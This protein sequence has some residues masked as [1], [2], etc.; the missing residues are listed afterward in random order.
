MKNL[1]FLINTLVVTT[2]FL[3]CSNKKN[4]MKSENQSV[5]EKPLIDN[6]ESNI[7]TTKNKQN[8]K[9][10]NETEN[11]QDTLNKST[12]YL[13]KENKVIKEAPKHNSPDQSEIDSIKK[14]KENFKK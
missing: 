2:M 5:V 14:T 8:N 11:N 10:M 12:K 1:S 13:N 3:S 7:D 4:N 6:A 9:M